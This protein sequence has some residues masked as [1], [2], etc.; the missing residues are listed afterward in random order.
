MRTHILIIAFAVTSGVSPVIAADS[1]DAQIY[2]IEKL[3]AKEHPRTFYDFFMRQDC[4]TIKTDAARKRQDAQLL[5]AKKADRET[6]ARKCI[7]SDL[8]RMEGLLRK[9]QAALQKSMNIDAAELALESAI[10]STSDRFLSDD[11]IKEIF[12]VATVNTNCDSI[13]YFLIGIDFLENGALRSH[14]VWAKS[15]PRG[16]EVGRNG[17]M[18][19]FYTGFND[20]ALERALARWGLPKL[21]NRNVRAPGD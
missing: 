4:I 3:C 10:G 14:R 5:A 8:E 15:A 2:E 17:Y 18:S 16:Y 9:S 11:N 12:I 21:T 19:D 20:S 13:F 7:A 6:R 1:W